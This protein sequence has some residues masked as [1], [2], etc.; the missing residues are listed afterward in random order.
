[1]SYNIDNWG[2]IDS[3]TTIT[4]G[5]W[6]DNGNTFKGA[7]FAQGSPE[8]AGSLL[9]VTNEGIGFGDDSKTWYQFDMTN[10]GRATRFRLNGGGLS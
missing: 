5:F 1:M 10:H 9:T 3:N 6:F 8:D 7:Q 2:F 4:V